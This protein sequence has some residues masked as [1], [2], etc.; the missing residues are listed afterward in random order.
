MS[1]GLPGKIRLALDQGIASDAA[2]L[3]RQAGYEC[4]HVS[5]VGL[6]KAEDTAVLEWA[7]LIDAVV[8]TLDADF[9][10]ALA[11]SG[12]SKPPVIRIR[13]EGR[14]AAAVASLVQRVIAAHDSQL[15]SG[16]MITVKARK[17]TCHMLP[18]GESK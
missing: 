11:V 17:T 10:A 8:I 12:A 13:M 5:E 6:A 15:R 3:L 1:E 2:A 4:L 14:N 7:L 9:H 16:C 18:V